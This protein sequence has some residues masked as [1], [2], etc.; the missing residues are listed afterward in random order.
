ML[1]SG[2]WSMFCES[3][4]TVDVAAKEIGGIILAGLCED[5]KE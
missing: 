1:G 4:Q 2:I 3:G 5:G